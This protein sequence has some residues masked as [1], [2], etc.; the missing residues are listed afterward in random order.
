[1]S[2]EVQN[3]EDFKRLKKLCEALGEHFDTVQVFATR[4][5]PE[6]GGTVHMNCGVG[7][8]FARRGQV[9]EWLEMPDSGPIPDDE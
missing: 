6:A 8:W 5:D 7:N 1:M 2:P 4:H 9:M 3:E